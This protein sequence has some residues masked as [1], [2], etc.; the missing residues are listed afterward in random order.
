MMEIL[1][2]KEELTIREDEFEVLDNGKRILICGRFQHINDKTRDL[3]INF[4]FDN[5]IPKETVNKAINLM[6]T[7]LGWGKNK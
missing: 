7:K 5:N 3:S 6:Y 4:C 1:T 2:N